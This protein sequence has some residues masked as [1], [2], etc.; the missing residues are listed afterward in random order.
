MAEMILRPATFADIAALVEHGRAFLSG[1][2]P[3]YT[4]DTDGLPRDLAALIASPDGFALVAEADGRVAGA[5]LG[6][7]FKPIMCVERD[8]REIAWWIEPE[9]R[10]SR[11]SLRM[12]GAFE[13]WG[14]ERGCRS[15]II[16]TVPD[17]S[18]PSLRSYLAR[19]GYRFAEEAH[20]R[21]LV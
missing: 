5:L 21:P 12:L 10:G 7:A 15:A 20:V 18:P 13:A 9:A 4:L 14:R 3:G 16:V 1:V 6:I 2:A 17:F 11:V 19:R 8:A